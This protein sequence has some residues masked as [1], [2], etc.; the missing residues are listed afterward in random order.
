M[1]S[2]YAVNILGLFRKG[3][4]KWKSNG[5]KKNV[6]LS[7]QNGFF[8]YSSQSKTVLVFWWLSKFPK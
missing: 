1:F 7:S 2:F 5:M 4:I 3:F 8:I 6:K